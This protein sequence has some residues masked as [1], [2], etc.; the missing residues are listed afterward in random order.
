MVTQQ[1]ERISSTSTVMVHVPISAT[2]FDT[3]LPVALGALPV[4]LAFVARGTKPGA[5]DWKV[6]A[7]SADGKKARIL[8]G[9]LNNGLLLVAR[10]YDVW[11]RVTD[12]PEVPEQPAPLGV[13]IF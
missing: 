3:G 7:W 8:V 11:W 13:V 4:R 12:L 10:S 2:D 1:P 9:P 5:G 6:A